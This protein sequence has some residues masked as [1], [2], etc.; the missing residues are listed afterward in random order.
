MIESITLKKV[1]SYPE[2]GCKIENLKKL[3]FFFGANGTGKSTIARFLHNLSLPEESRNSIFSFCEPKNIDKTKEV[4]KVFNADYVKANFYNSDSL[5][6]VFS[7]NEKNETIERKILEKEESIK[8]IKL[9]IKS[10]NEERKNLSDSLDDIKEDYLNKVFDERKVFE[11][12]SAAKAK[13][14]HSGSKENFFQE[15]TN[16]QDSSA[17]D[18]NSLKQDYYQLFSNDASL[19]TELISIKDLDFLELLR[20]SEINPILNTVIV[21]NEDVSIKELIEKWENRKWVEQGKGYLIKTDGKCPFCQ[22]KL[23]NSFVED[24]EKFFNEQY[25]ESIDKIQNLEKQYISTVN[26]LLNNLQTLIYQYDENREVTKLRQTVLEIFENNK[27][28]FQAKLI[29]PNEKMEITSF[30]SLKAEAERINNAITQRNKLIQNKTQNIKQYNEDVLNYLASKTKKVIEE[31]FITKQNIEDKIQN[32]DN[33]NSTNNTELSSLENEIK[34]LRLQTVN[35]EEAVNNINALLKNA[36]FSNF[37]IHEIKKAN[38]ISKYQILRDESDVQ[39]AFESLSEGEKNFISF[40][41]FYQQ[42]LG[43]SE[44]EKTLKKIIVIDDPVSSMDSQVLFFVNSLIQKLIVMKQNKKIEA[45]KGK[46]FRNEFR[47][48]MISQVFILTHNVYFYKEVSLDNR[49]FCKDVRYYFLSK[50]EKISCITDFPADNNPIKDDYTLLWH[51]LKKYREDTTGNLSN[52]LI[53][54][55]MRRIIES[56]VYFVKADTDMWSV[57]DSFEEGSDKYFSVFSLIAEINDESHKI[58]TLSNQYYQRLS[59]IDTSILFE[60]FETVFREI[61]EEHYNYMMSL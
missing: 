47:N 35:T 52:I 40:L 36:G 38:N 26:K 1:A 18:F 12:A 3:N 61:G 49:Q 46:N 13:I 56:Y 60:A 29:T 34:P 44:S 50:K 19:I 14:K 22:R 5:D 53:S 4:I 17:K 58:C 23:D 32:I 55:T 24:L 51:E 21:G 54:N 7:L 11:F 31:Y 28:I 48:E 10:N 30:E 39:S 45:L 33:E 25:K 8:Q 20:V 6:G 43:Y 37:F 42:C 59:S 57:L 2:E 27:R 16:R 41:Y 9:K 15:M